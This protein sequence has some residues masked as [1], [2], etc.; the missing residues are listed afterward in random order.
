VDPVSAPSSR[1]TVNG[2]RCGRRR[3]AAYTSRR[4]VA[5]EGRRGVATGVAATAAQPVDL[6]LPRESR[7]GWG[8]G[9]PWLP[10]DSSAPSG[11]FANIH[12]VSTGCAALHPWL[13][14]SAPPGRCDELMTAPDAGGCHTSTRRGRGVRLDVVCT[15]NHTSPSRRVAPAKQRDKKS[16]ALSGRLPADGSCARTPPALRM[17]TDPGPSPSAGSPGSGAGDRGP[18]DLALKP[19]TSPTPTPTPQGFQGSDPRGIATASSP[20]EAQIPCPAS[21]TSPSHPSAPPARNKT[22]PNFY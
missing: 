8:G 14:P 5:P 3:V 21:I 13:Q 7:P 17:P 6:R 1:A 16:T 11:R 22:A 4:G 15:L 10:H 19:T 12:R 18:G 20:R 9:R 2:R